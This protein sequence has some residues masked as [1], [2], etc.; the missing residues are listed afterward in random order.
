MKFIKLGGTDLLLYVVVIRREMNAPV[1]VVLSKSSVY[2]H[3]TWRQRVLLKHE[4]V[5]Y[6]EMMIIEKKRSFLF[7]QTRILKNYQLGT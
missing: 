2:V 6:R 1:S 4:I 3:R 5:K 7:S